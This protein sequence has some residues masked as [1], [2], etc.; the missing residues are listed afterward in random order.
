MNLTIVQ[1][2]YVCCCMELTKAGVCYGMRLTIEG[3]TNVCCYIHL[4][5]AGVCYGMRL[6]IA[7]FCERMLL[8]A[9]HDP[10]GSR[11]DHARA[12]IR[13]GFLG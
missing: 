13:G 1:V 11:I 5:K 2:S 7:R 9:S 4:T 6:T 12:S 3:L 8:H 10:R